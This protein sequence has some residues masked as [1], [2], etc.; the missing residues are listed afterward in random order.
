MAHPRPLAGHGSFTYPGSAGKGVDDIEASFVDSQAETQPASVVKFWDD[1]CNGNDNADTCDVDCMGFGA[2]CSDAL[3]CGGSLDEN[4]DG[5][6]DECNND[7]ICDDAVADPGELW[8]PNHKFEDV[9]VVGVTDPDGDVVTITITALAQDEPLEGLGDGNTCPDADGVGTDIAS[10]RAERSGTRQT[11]G[12]GRVYHISFAADDGRGGEC[13]G[14]V[15]VCVSHDQGRGNTCVDG[16]PVF[17]STVCEGD[18]AAAAS[19]AG[20]GRN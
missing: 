15:T 20:F 4:G 6:P 10:V 11:P 7:P 1:D 5:T 12:D 9:S 16:G 18:L 3:E 13:S 2:R 19:A 14:T 17:D 8:P